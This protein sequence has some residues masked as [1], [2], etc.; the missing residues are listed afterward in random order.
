MPGL[1]RDT[2]TAVDHNGSRGVYGGARI[3][4][5]LHAAGVPIGG[6]VRGPAARAFVRVSA[7]DGYA[8]IFTLAE[9]E[10][11]QARCAPILAETRN[12]RPLAPGTGPLRIVA[13][14]DRTHAR[15]VREVTRLTVV[16]SPK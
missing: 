6:A 3:A 5:I 9:L 11:T 2:V 8:A 16:V 14:C 15:W 4:D 1:A 12:G 13:P 7:V 10:T